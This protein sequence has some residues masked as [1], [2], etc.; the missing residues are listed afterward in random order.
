MSEDVYG[1]PCRACT[2]F[3][4]WM[5][6]APTSGAEAKASDDKKKKNEDKKDGHLERR[7]VHPAWQGEK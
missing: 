1:R 3:K 2:D 5:K 4:Q 7:E 6:T